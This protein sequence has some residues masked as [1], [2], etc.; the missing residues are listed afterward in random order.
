MQNFSA[1]SFHNL[2]MPEVGV[3]LTLIFTL[4]PESKD[5]G[6]DS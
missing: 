1:P 6:N 3:Q 4:K 5:T 2:E